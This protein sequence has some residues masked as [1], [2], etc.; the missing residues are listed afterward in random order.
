MSM[1][2][3][4]LGPVVIPMLGLNTTVTVVYRTTVLTSDGFETETESVS[5]HEVVLHP[6]T[7]RELNRAVGGQ[8]TD[9]GLVVYSQQ[10]L[11]ERA[12]LSYAEPGGE[13]KRWLIIR[14]EDWSAQAGHYRA[15][16][17]AP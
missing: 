1:L 12:H 14:C 9:G 5:E 4:P 2:P 8:R 17:V 11:P 15:W 10:P 3:L 13:T 7:A 16:C 6:S